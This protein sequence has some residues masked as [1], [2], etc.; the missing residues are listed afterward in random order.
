MTQPHD[1]GQGIGQEIRQEIDQEI[2]QERHLDIH[3]RDDGSIDVA[4]YQAQAMA[5]RAQT[6][7]NALGPNALAKLRAPFKH[8]GKHVMSQAMSMLARTVPSR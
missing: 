6:I 2:G 3:R 1:I 5:L 7:G 4:F 8:W